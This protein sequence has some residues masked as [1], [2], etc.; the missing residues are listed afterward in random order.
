M[1]QLEKLL[2]PSPA[3][4]INPLAARHLRGLK[5]LPWTSSSFPKVGASECAFELQRNGKYR[6]WPSHSPGK[7]HSAISNKSSMAMDTETVRGTSNT[8]GIYFPAATRA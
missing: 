7:L 6:N 3:Q 2:L 1:P 4:S 8:P 5:N